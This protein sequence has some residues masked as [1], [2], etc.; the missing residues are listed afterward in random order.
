MNTIDLRKDVVYKA[1]AKPAIVDIPEMLFVMVDGEGAPENNP[2]F[3]DAMAIL[4][5]VVYTIKFWDKQHAIPADYAKFKLTPLEALWWQKD[6]K[7]FTSSSRPDDWKW[8]VMIRLPEFVTPKFFKEVIKEL[9]AKKKSDIYKRARLEKFKEGDCVQVMYIG[10]YDHEEA[11]IREMHAFALEA[12]YKL[13]GKHHELYF[14]DPRRTAP[15]KLKTIIR[16]PVV[17]GGAL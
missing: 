5:G 16:Q 9:T 17:K 15:E 11:D 3:Q 4:F 10:P 8:T 6:G 13:S 7:A 12:G 2:A 1:K 14:S